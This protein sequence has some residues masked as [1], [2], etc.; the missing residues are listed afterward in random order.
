MPEL[1]ARRPQPLAT[2]LMTAFDILQTHCKH[3]TAV[4][5]TVE[6]ASCK[7]SCSSGEVPPMESGPPAALCPKTVEQP[8]GP[9]QGP[10]PPAAQ[11][12]IHNF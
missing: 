8:P 9:S 5:D 6:V 11:P 4:P 12:S 2:S 3:D 7:S 10:S 1:E